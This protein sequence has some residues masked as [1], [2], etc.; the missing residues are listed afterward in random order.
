[1]C[2]ISNVNAHL[3]VSILK[4][5][6]VQ[7]V[8]NIFAT[9]RIDRANVQVSQVPSLRRFLRRNLPIFTLLGKTVENSLRERSCV[10]RELMQNHVC[11]G[12]EFALFTDDANELTNW[13][14]TVDLPVLESHDNTLA[15]DL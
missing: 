3:I 11:L 7:G 15:I 14:R 13:E 8:I 12:S 4:F 2:H 5:N 6:T 1:M 9:G 10:D